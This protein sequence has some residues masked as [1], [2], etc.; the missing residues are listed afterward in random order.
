MLRNFGKRVP[1]DGNTAVASMAYALSESSFIYPITPATTM[2]ELIDTWISQGRKNVW[3]NKVHLRMLQSEAGAVAAVHGA[4]AA[5][6]LTSTYTASQGFLLMVPDLYKIAAEYCPAVIHVAARSL[7]SGGL[8]IYN[9]HADIYAGRSTGMPMLCSNGVQEAQDLAA[10]AHLTMMKTGIPF[11]HFFDGFRTSH[12][13]N[14]YE[15]ISN[16]DLY[17]LVDETGIAKSVPLL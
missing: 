7:A 6:S 8:S 4:S 15:E 1:G 17:K 16:A 2:G 3:G 14:T 13:I 10:V 5:G 12:E 11:V 9:D